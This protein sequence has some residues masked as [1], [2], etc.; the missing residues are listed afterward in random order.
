M[1]P[2]QA[3]LDATDE[4]IE[5]HRQWLEPSALCPDTGKLILAIQSYLV[6]LGSS[7]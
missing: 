6:R 2:R 7:S 3:Y 4:H 5:A 1:T